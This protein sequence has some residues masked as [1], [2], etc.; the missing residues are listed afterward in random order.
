MTYKV[1]DDVTNG[2][3]T[4]TI[5]AINE[6]QRQVRWDD[7]TKTWESAGLM[8]VHS[9]ENCQYQGVKRLY[10]P[11]YSCLDHSHWKASTSAV[12]NCDSP[13]SDNGNNP[14]TPTNPVHN[15]E[16]CRHNAL[17][18]DE[19]PCASCGDGDDDNWEAVIG[20]AKAAQH[21]IDSAMQPI[22]VAQRLLTPE[23]FIGALKFNE[24]KYRMRCDHKGQHDSDIAKALQY[25]YWADLAQQ[26]HRIDP[27]VDVP[28]QD[29]EW[30]GI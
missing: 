14:E 30:K 2:F 15:C 27:T 19:E 10:E 24:I 26:G 18:N 9:C 5:I 3:S 23:Q 16:N 12:H 4:G 28:P 6:N 11:C 29:Y 13:Q 8:P 1:G 7:G 25:A 17:D 21:Y 22:E 20:T